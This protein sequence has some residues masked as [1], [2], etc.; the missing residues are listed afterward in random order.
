MSICVWAL[1]LLQTKETLEMR[2]TREKNWLI[3]RCNKAWQ[4]IQLLLGLACL[5]CRS[6][7]FIT[8]VTAS[9]L[10]LVVPFSLPTS[11]ET[12]KFQAVRKSR[13]FQKPFQPVPRPNFRQEQT[14]PFAGS[15]LLV[16][17]PNI[18]PVLY[19]RSALHLRRAKY[20]PKWHLGDTWALASH[21]RSERR[22]DHAF[23]GLSPLFANTKK[24][25]A[26]VL[27]CFLL[28]GKLVFE[29]QHLAAEPSMPRM[30]QGV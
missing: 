26:I 3:D 14:K 15:E 9:L 19:S 27:P 6:H 22:S 18:Q 4:V 11:K 12:S 2:D 5:Q 1:P 21:T 8:A 10:C 7:V 23:M 17:F 13:H 30:L 29:L 24:L 16:S 20:L 28:V 25:S